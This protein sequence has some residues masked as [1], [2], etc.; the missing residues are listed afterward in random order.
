MLINVS[1]T[2]SKPFYVNDVLYP[3]I[4][5]KEERLSKHEILSF[6]PFN[7]LFYRNYPIYCFPVQLIV[8]TEIIPLIF[9][10][11]KWVLIVYEPSEWKWRMNET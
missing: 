3:S 1:P 9:S 10:Y 4:C 6:S 11:V 7:S 8:L 5:T 2:S